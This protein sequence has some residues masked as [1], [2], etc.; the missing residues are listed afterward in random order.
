[1]RMLHFMLL[2]MHYVIT[3]ALSNTM[4]QIKNNFAI[5]YSQ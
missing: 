2:H 1:M 4:K 5:F 3:Y